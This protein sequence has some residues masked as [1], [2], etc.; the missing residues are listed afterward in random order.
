MQIT[1]IATIQITR[2]ITIRITMQ[3]I[4]ARTIQIIH[5]ITHHQTKNK[6]KIIKITH[7]IMHILDINGKRITQ[8]HVLS[9]QNHN[10][11]HGPFH[12][13]DLLYRSATS[14]ASIFLK[15][16][17]RNRRRNDKIRKI[18]ANNSILSSK[19]LI[20][21]LFQSKLIDRGHVESELEGCEFAIKGEPLFI[22]PSLSSN[23]DLSNMSLYDIMNRCK[24]SKQKATKLIHFFRNNKIQSSQ[25]NLLYILNERILTLELLK[26]LPSDLTLN[27]QRISD[28]I[29]KV[30][31]NEDPLNQARDLY[32][33]LAD[34]ELADENEAMQ[35]MWR[36]LSKSTHSFHTEKSNLQKLYKCKEKYNRIS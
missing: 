19:E 5:Q 4:N 10:A 17:N 8:H 31:P 14:L 25:L 16:V 21:T 32:L 1:R 18:I 30:N 7:Q 2:T 9:H 11:T 12:Q 28:M 6:K 20:Q 15:A 13:T 3:E 24:I 23:D 36:S 26:A 35:N 27:N 29:A 33:Q 34:V 22:P